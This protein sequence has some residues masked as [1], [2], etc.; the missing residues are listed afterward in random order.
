MW[1]S[2]RGWRCATSSGRR[3]GSSRSWY[4]TRSPL[5]Q[6]KPCNCRL[7]RHTATSYRLRG[8]FSSHP[9]SQDDL[10]QYLL[11]RPQ[12]VRDGQALCHLSR[13][14]TSEQGVCVQKVAGASPDCWGPMGRLRVK[15]DPPGRGDN[16]FVLVS[17]SHHKTSRLW[18][19][20]QDIISEWEQRKKRR[21][22]GGALRESRK[23]VTLILF[24]LFVVVFFP[25]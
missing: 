22:G 9:L 20:A 10:P 3:C 11:L 7:T 24:Y 13:Q 8:R 17:H 12:A 4:R 14:D 6:G 19:L 16:V 25:L 15:E 1:G 5:R 18:T 23:T 2:A 21:V